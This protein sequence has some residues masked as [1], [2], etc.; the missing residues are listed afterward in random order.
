MEMC[1]GFAATKQFPVLTKAAPCCLLRLQTT[2]ES[3]GPVFVRAEMILAPKAQKDRASI[4]PWC[5]ASAVTQC[6]TDLR[7][8]YRA[9]VTQTQQ[10][11]STTL[12]QRLSL[13]SVGFGGLFFIYQRGWDYIFTR[14]RKSQHLLNLF[15][16]LSLSTKGKQQTYKFGAG[17]E[18]WYLVSKNMYSLKTGQ[19]F[20]AINS[21]QFILAV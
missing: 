14:N 16:C 2:A 10:S 21:I 17:R 12:L 20:I 9:D 6:D 19:H 1:K 3:S 5:S 8:K 7:W 4:P 11:L 18:N 15:S 13:S